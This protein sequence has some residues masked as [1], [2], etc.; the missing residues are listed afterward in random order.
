MMKSNKNGFTLIEL[1]VVI[2]IM[3]ILVSLAMPRLN[4][5]I[6]NANK[7][8]CNSN[9]KSLEQAYNLELV[10]KG[11]EHSDDMFTDFL[12]DYNQ[13]ICPKDGNISYLNE[14]V[15]CSVHDIDE[16]EEEEDDDVP[17]L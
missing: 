12:G 15:I 3:G 6:D 2:S 8:V 5:F 13:T 1:I 4:N 10:I 7:E 17:Y 11:K 9:C 14:K 16:D